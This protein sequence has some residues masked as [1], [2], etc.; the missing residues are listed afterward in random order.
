MGIKINEE[1]RLFIDPLT[2]SERAMLERSLLAEGCRD[3]LV[4][5]GDILVDGHNRYEICQKHGI[6]FNTVT[7]DKFQNIEQ[8]MLWMIDNQLSRRSV[9]DF[10]RGML[11]LRKKALLTA[12]EKPPAVDE[13]HQTEG[14][15]AAP[16]PATRTSRKE[17]AQ[18][19]GVSSHTIA[20]IEKIQ[21]TAAP[22]LIDAVRVG[23]ISIGAAATVASLP[24]EEQVAAVAGGR[25]E[26][27]QAAKQVREA[28][29]PAKPQQEAHDALPVGGDDLAALRAMNS[30][31]Q[32]EN[33]A[34]KERVAALSAE[35]ELA[36]RAA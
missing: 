26:L 31:L 4:L 23:T 1:L 21:K 11:A 16:A 10:Q 7:N 15:E 32:A 6:A 30:A 5:W 18:I 33:L 24:N 14:E 34:L 25:K 29:M 28:R 3:P 27:R 17:V 13:N 8:V 35:L 12:G 19:A 22:E 9:T 36:K 2:D 20:Q